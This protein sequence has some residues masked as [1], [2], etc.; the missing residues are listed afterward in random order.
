MTDFVG[1]VSSHEAAEFTNFS[2][3]V[4]VNLTTLVLGAP[5]TSLRL[6]GPWARDNIIFYHLFCSIRLL[7]LEGKFFSFLQW[8][9]AFA[10]SFI[11]GSCIISD[12]KSRSQSF[13]RNLLWVLLLSLTSWIGTKFILTTTSATIC[14]VILFSSE[15]RIIKFFKCRSSLECLRAEMLRLFLVGGR[16]W[17]WAPTT[18]SD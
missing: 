12:L 7:L 1:C 3:K 15:Q 13:L 11:Y 16:G 4:R 8:S 18:A 9:W 5:Y 10:A 17:S 14:L 2:L 6:G